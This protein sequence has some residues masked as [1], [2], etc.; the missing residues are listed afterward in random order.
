VDEFPLPISG[1]GCD[2]L[3]EDLQLLS[4]L[5]NPLTNETL[6]ANSG[7]HELIVIAMAIITEEEA[8]CGVELMLDVESIP[9]FL[10][11]ERP[12]GIDEPIQ[13]SRSFFYKIFASPRP[14]P[15]QGRSWLSARQRLAS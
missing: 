1:L 11:S 8:G 3:A 10:E 12:V 9:V 5:F 7:D 14:D 15:S 2:F 13:V 4:N 6:K